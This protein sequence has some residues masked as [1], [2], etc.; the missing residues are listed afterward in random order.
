MKRG[1][2]TFQL[3]LCVVGPV[4]IGNGYEIQKK[5]YQFLDQQ[6]I[7]VVDIEKLY[8]LAQKKKLTKD[9]ERFFLEDSRDDLKYWAIR[10]SISKKEMEDCMKYTMDAG[11]IQREKGRMQIMACIK[12]PY[13]NPY[14][15]GS[16]IKGMLRTILL[17]AELM[18]Q[19]KKYDIDRENIVLNLRQEN[20]K[21]K[22]VLARDIK[23]IECKTF[24][25]LNRPDQKKTDA[26]NDNMSGI[27]IS[28]SEPLSCNDL[29]LCQK[30]E[31]HMDG[32]YKTLNLLRECIKPGTQ[33]KS[34]LTIDR[35]M[36]DITIEEI[37]QAIELFYNMYYDTF[38]RKF[39]HQR[40]GSSATVFLGGGSGFVSKTMIY[41]L[42]G[43]IEGIRVASKIFENT[44]VPSKHKHFKD[45][46]L[47]VS[48]HIL[49]CTKYRGKEYMMGQ[50][51]V[52]IY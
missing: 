11:D 6:T 40:R 15:P 47:G 9:L 27:I 32:S 16:S 46:R 20:V 52:N 33:I 34:T 43:E 4:F 44:G 28:D 12:D 17:C 29:I 31:Q 24:H 1:L 8:L 37:H 35:T 19:E 26:V 21:R 25:T 10:N 39:P 51:E 42:F 48:P 49:K 38:Q 36:N 7:G 18:K 30:W 13:G 45:V 41:A 22:Q 3:E 5:E 50:C 14:I 2:E 23:N